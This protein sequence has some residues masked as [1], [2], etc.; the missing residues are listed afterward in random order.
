MTITN[1]FQ[2]CIQCIMS[3]RSDVCITFDDSG[4]CHHCIRYATTY[5]DRIEAADSR[6][7]VLDKLVEKIKKD[8]RG[9]EYDCIL[10]V[11]GGVDSTYV[12]YLVKS[13][14][15]RPLAVHLDNGW[16]SE[17]AIINIEKTLTK[18]G[19]DLYT[20]VLDWEEFRSL[21]IS[22][23]SASVPDGEV[24]TDHA[25]T[26]LLWRQASHRGIKYIMSGMNYATESMSVP[27]WAYGHS[28]WKYIKSVHNKFGKGQKLSTYPHYSLP[29]LLFVNAFKGIRTV[30]ILNYISYNKDEAMDIISKE[31]DWT[32]YGG[33]HY[34]S[35][36]TRFYQGY[37]LPEKFK[38]D[39][40]YGH[41]S[42]LIVNGQ[43]TKEE[44]LIEIGKN[45][46]SDADRAQDIEY[47]KK[48]LMFKDVEFNALLSAPLKTFRD[49]PNNYVFVRLLKKVVNFMRSKSIYTK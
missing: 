44:A 45:T 19:V 35:I 24:V 37:F 48:K 22:F 32:Y 26:A 39:K 21:Q 27:N 30:S 23:L 43:I 16:N 12:A 15:L 40:R 2:E 10:G 17:L 29:Y 38:I 7:E 3:N 46:Y 18:L 9:N 34:E 6:S 28:D 33:K 8:G 20:H 5:S 13:L 11:S 31:L 36:Y 42:D 47:V 4:L 25:I 14:G 49:Y 1:K 41:L